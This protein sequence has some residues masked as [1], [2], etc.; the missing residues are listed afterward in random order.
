M[1]E[2][3]EAARPECESF[4]LELEDGGMRKPKPPKPSAE[5]SLVALPD[6]PCHPSAAPRKGPC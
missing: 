1:A 5:E 6:L 3:L 2:L 4:E